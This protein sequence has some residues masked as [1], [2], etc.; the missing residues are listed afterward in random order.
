MLR[1]ALR[2]LPP[3]TLSYALAASIA[4]AVSAAAGAIAEDALDGPLVVR[5]LVVVSLGSAL[6]GGALFATEALLRAPRYRGAEPVEVGRVFYTALAALVAAVL[7]GGGALGTEMFVDRVSTGAPGPNV[8]GSRSPTEL[9]LDWSVP[10]RM[11]VGDPEPTKAVLASQR[12]PVD[13]E[14]EDIE[15]PGCVGTGYTWDVKTIDGDPVSLSLRHVAGCHFQTVFPDEAAYDVHVQ[16]AAG[17]A[18]D[19]RVDVRDWLVVSLGDS[20]AAGEGNALPNGRWRGG[21]DDQPCHRSPVAGPRLAALELEWA[22]PKT[23]VTFVHLACT[24]ATVRGGPDEPDD[25]RPAREKRLLSPASKNGQLEEVEKLLPRRTQVDA[26]L[27][28]VGANDVGFSN[29]L[30]FCLKTFR[31]CFDRPYGGSP[32]L[33]LLIRQRI[34]DLR[35]TYLALSSAALFAGHPRAVFITEYFDFTAGKKGKPCRILPLFS[36]P[37]AT[38]AHGV[39]GRLNAEV[40]KAAADH[41]WNFVG[42]IAG[43]FRGHGYCAKRASWVIPIKRIFKHPLRPN[44]TAPFHPNERGQ[45][46]YGE[47]LFAEL[48]KHLSE[49]PAVPPGRG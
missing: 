28:S 1:K 16:N 15:H 43:P 6:L 14:L 26:I 32:R 12:Y 47:R 30:R 20:V 5:I 13:F 2:F 41:D 38:W 21:K 23:S 39:L 25:K 11:H 22:D 37:E 34:E 10:D 3:R 48:R 40:R 27:L 4:I 44:P 36:P 29:V 46:L 49:A 18:T 17:S 7:A 31:P 42:G 24:G 45:Q 8:A 35:S 9:A 33:D 19:A